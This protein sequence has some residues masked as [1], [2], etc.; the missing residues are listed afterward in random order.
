[1]L[2]HYSVSQSNACSAT[3]HI[4]DAVMPVE[5]PC[6]NLISLPLQAFT[7]SAKSCLSKAQSYSTPSSD[8]SV[9]VVIT[10]TN[11]QIVNLPAVVDTPVTVQPLQA[12][13]QSLVL[14]N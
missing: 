4:G 11:L 14:V 6:H 5:H 7:V 12:L 10:V 1:M 9:N 3:P 8:F 13:L 2:N